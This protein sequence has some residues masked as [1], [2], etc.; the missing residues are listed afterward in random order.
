[1]FLESL[2]FP[3]HYPPPVLPTSV[4]FQRL[5]CGIGEGHV[6]LSHPPRG[7]RAA[8]TVAGA[9]WLCSPTLQGRGEEEKVGDGPQL[10]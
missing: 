7:L 1:M 2:F 6:C 9:C 4:V 8:L 5:G 3:P 10:D